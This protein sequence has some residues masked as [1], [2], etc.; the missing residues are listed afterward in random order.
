MKHPDT[1]GLRRAAER[2]GR[3]AEAAAAWLLRRKG[4]RVLAR[5]YRT[6]AGEIDLIV[7]RGRSVVFVEVKERPEE[8]AALE[9]I[10]QTSRRRIARAAALW[11][12]RNPAAV[13]L[14][15]RFDVILACPGRLPR[16]LTAVFDSGGNVW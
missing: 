7:R 8:A 3:R 4:Y 10:T 16:H 6:P 2:R 15:Q 1:A 13:D 9:A 14:D 11:V 12:S 5:R